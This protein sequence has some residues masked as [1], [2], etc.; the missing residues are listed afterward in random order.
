MNSNSILRST[1]GIM[2]AGTVLFG[3]GGDDTAP[4]AGGGVPAAPA[5]LTAAPL[6]GPAIHVTWKD[7]SMDED[8]FVLE[9][10]MDSGDFAV[11]TNPVFNET[12]HHDATV[13]AMMT[14]TYRI[15]AKNAKGLSPF[16][17]EA[18]ATAP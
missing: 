1:A 8:S 7:H 3:C 10:K 11:L 13:M 17:N 16:S 14:Y 9:R 15:A 12:T 4:P 18:T 6:P 2:L 5:E